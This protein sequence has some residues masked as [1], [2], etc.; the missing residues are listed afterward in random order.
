MI[1]NEK[2]EDPRISTIVKIAK[3]LE[4]SEHEFTKLCGYIDDKKINKR[5]KI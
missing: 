3:A 1:I 2:R 5:R 4:L